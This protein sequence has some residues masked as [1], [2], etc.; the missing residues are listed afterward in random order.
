LCTYSS[1]LIRDYPYEFEDGGEV[2]SLGYTTAEGK[3]ARIGVI[4]PGTT[5]KFNFGQAE[6]REEILVTSGAIRVNGVNYGIFGDGKG[7]LVFNNVIVFE[8]GET[9]KLECRQPATYHCTYD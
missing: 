6:H 2:R 9:I 7:G 8:R 3:E 4:I 1:K 5:G